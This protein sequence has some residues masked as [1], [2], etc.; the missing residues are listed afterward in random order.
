L[1]NNL[2]CKPYRVA[3]AAGSAV[4]GVQP[5]LCTIAVHDLELRTG[6]GQ[7]VAFRVPGQVLGTQVVGG[8]AGRIHDPYGDVIRVGIGAAVGDGRRLADGFL[9]AEEPAGGDDQQQYQQQY[10]LLVV[11]H[12]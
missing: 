6:H 9:L 5:P 12:R 2:T 1:N 3:G 7:L 11:V 4:F 10:G 8:P